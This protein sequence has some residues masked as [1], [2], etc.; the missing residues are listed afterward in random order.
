MY[1]FA[2]LIHLASAIVWLGGM[3]FMLFILRPAALQTMPPHDL[4]QLMLRVWQ[5]FFAVVAV[6]AVLLLWSGSHMYKTAYVASK[7]VAAVGSVPLG[8]NLMLGLGVLMFLTFGHLFF[9]GFRK[10]KR[11]VQAA[12]WPQAAKSAQLVRW[13]VMVNFCLGWLAILAVRL[14]R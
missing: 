3:T 8:W 6:T 10:F 14:V 13:L 2:K 12:D 11:A 5:R 9:S 1:E 4:A 7:S